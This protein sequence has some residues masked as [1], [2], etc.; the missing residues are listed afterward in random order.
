MTVPS[1]GSG[2]AYLMGCGLVVLGGL[3]LSLGVLCIRGASASDAWQY[4]FWRA[5]GF[6]LVLAF[7]AALRHGTSPLAQIRSLGRFAWVSALAMVAS[8]VCFV[9][10]MKS[11]STAEVFFLMSLAPL[12]AA[13]LA[14][15]ILGERMGGLGMLAIAVALCGVALMSGLN[16]RPD[17]L[18]G[19]LWEGDWTAPVLALCTAFTF[20]LYSLATRGARREDL[21]AALVAVGIV[22]TAVSAAV[23]LWLGL[24]FAASLG[25]AALGLLHGGVI[26]AIGL[27]LLA[28]GSRTV[29]GVTLVMLAQAETVAAPIW[30][31]LV[32]D[33]TT[34]MSV[35]AGGALILL[36]VI[37]Q[38]SDGARRDRGRGA[39]GRS[40]A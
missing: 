30:T 38:A 20:A 12:I 28:R 32:F 13:V 26:L 11:G 7:V 16:A 1:V 17:G 5:L 15:P 31:Y 10:A 19:A 2:R 27:V 24:P 3:V 39:A 14:R 29:P 35:V 22:T 18:H 40:P 6:G 25:D 9:A 23:M 36:A 21:D 4:L 34:T 8:Q 33:E 37:M